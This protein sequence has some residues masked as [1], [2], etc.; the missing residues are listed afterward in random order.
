[1]VPYYRN[2]DRQ[3]GNISDFA[4]S[5]C[6][7]ATSGQIHYHPCSKKVCPKTKLMETYAPFLQATGRFHLTSKGCHRSDPVSKFHDNS[8]DISVAWFFL[9]IKPPSKIF[10]TT[11]AEY[12]GAPV[13]PGEL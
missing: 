11:Y 6:A 10:F 9:W 3:F 1:M 13:A 4:I 7:I 5:D 12:A 8:V 2:G